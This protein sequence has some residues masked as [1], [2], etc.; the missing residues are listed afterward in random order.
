MRNNKLLNSR[1]T[2][3]N[4]ENSEEEFELDRR[5]FHKQSV[6]AL[7]SQTRARYVVR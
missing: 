5:D 6:M 1:F 4:S 3:E 2:E 7:T